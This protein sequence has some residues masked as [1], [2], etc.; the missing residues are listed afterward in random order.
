MNDMVTLIAQTTPLE[1]DPKTATRT[2]VESDLQRLGE[3][4]FTAYEPGIAGES[5]E[6]AMAEMKASFKGQY[7]QFLPESSHVALDEQGKPVAAILLVEHALGDDVPD[8][9]FIFELFTDR[10]YR[11]RGLAEEL[12]LAAMDSLFNSGHQRVALRVKEDNSAALALYLSLD[13]HRWTPEDA[14]G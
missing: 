2:V 9:P 14:E 10:E 7:G 6:A 8:A 3:L 13:F 5:V 11:R 12:V 1:R 4:Y